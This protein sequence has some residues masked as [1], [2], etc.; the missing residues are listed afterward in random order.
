MGRP[1][2]QDRKHEGQQVRPIRNRTMTGSSERYKSEEM[3]VFA[4]VPASA[5]CHQTAVPPGDETEE[6]ES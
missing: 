1:E 5:G 4:G 6:A 3:R 2:P